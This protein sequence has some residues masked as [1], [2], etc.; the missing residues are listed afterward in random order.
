M[1]NE[2]GCPYRQL[3]DESLNARLSKDDMVVIKKYCESNK[4]I[5][6]LVIVRKVPFAL[7]LSIAALLIII[8][9]SYFEF[10][11]IPI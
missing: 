10:A 9:G 2:K 3:S 6:S 11:D 7:Y 4:A 5:S 1:T 8:G